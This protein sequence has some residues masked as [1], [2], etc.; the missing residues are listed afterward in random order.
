MQT[1][2]AG[3]LNSQQTPFFLKSPPRI[4]V[5]MAVQARLHLCDAGQTAHCV[6]RLPVSRCSCGSAVS[7]PH[8][9]YV[10]TICP[11]KHFHSILDKKK[12][13]HPT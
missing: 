8:R 6:S 9:P 2:E 10:Q 4:P 11:R 3:T 12:T 1:N 13:N 5:Q 7:L